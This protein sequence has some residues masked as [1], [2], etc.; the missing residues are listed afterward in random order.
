MVG[1]RACRLVPASAPRQ[2][3]QRRARGLIH[4]T[5][6]GDAMPP[7]SDAEPN[8]GIRVSQGYILRAN[9]LSPYTNRKQFPHRYS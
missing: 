2:L 4:A 7:L 1:V 5:S 6:R 3:F 9:N 8:D